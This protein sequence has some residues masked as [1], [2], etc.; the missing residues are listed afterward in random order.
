[1][2]SS[3]QA[4][5]APVAYVESLF[6]QER[7]PYE[8]GWQPSTLPITLT[9]LGEF[10]TLLFAKTPENLPL[11]IEIL[12]E[13]TYRQVLADYLALLQKTQRKMR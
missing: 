10:V 3:P 4:Q 6:K 5:S 12:T 11:G 9:S 8:L 13:G 7:L 1:M 2:G